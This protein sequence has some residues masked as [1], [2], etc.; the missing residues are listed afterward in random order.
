MDWIELIQ[1]RPY[2][3]LDKDKAT[4]AFHQL[5]D[6]DQEKGLT[7][8]TIFR[9]ATLKNDICIFFSWSS[10][11]PENAKSNLGLQLAAMFSEF[12]HIYHSTWSYYTR[13]MAT[14]RRRNRA[15]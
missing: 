2:T 10:E 4:A 11:V 3:P 5:A 15:G 9:D 7:D 14:P 8:I 1:I 6:L 12:G 13:L